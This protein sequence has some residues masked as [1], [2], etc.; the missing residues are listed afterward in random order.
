ME[1]SICLDSLSAISLRVVRQIVPCGHAYHKTCIEEWAKE[2]NTC[3]NC[4]GPVKKIVCCREYII[5][6]KPACEL[7]TMYPEINT[8]RQKYLYFNY[9][10]I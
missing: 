10:K 4:R 8:D 1:C 9:Q 5:I 2:A 7:N 3:P 6:M